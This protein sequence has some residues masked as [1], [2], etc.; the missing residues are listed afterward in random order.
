[1]QQ[2]LCFYKMISFIMSQYVV[3]CGKNSYLLFE[4]QNVLHLFSKCE[5]NDTNML[6]VLWLPKCTQSYLVGIHRHTHHMHK[7]L[8]TAQAFI[9]RLKPYN[10]NTNT[11]T[12]QIELSV[13]FLHSIAPP[14]TPLSVFILFLNTFFLH[15]LLQHHT[16]PLVHK[17][18]VLLFL[19]SSLF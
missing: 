1:M 10:L 9:F 18:I 3:K 5:R 13:L 2:T 16:S 19:P 8:I 11:H 4:K 14:K 6:W 17:L 15:F 12:C 7:S